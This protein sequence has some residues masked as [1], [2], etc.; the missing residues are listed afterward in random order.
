MNL[1]SFTTIESALRQFHLVLIDR[2][3]ET[4]IRYLTEREIEWCLEKL[5]EYED[6]PALEEY[7]GISERCDELGAEVNDLI[8]RLENSDKGYEKGYQAGIDHIKKLIKEG[9]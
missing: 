8:E 4:G 2:K 7:D 3:K 9:T 1:L 5:E 6:R